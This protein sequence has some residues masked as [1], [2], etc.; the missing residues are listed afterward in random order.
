MVV[1]VRFL[2]EAQGGHRPV[3]AQVFGFEMCADPLHV[4]WL[5]GGGLSWILDI[6]DLVCVLF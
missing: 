5:E 4:G 2:D 3:N 1:W 6:T